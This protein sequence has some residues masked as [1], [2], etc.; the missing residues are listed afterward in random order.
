MKK[1]KDSVSR[2]INQFLNSRLNTGNLYYGNSHILNSGANPER[3]WKDLKQ[4]VELRPD[5]DV[6]DVGCAEGLLSFEVAKHVSSVHGLD[7][8]PER[9]KWARKEAEKRGVKNVTFKS[10]SI[11]STPINPG[12]YDVVLFL[13][14]FMK[15]SG[16][17]VVG[18]PVLKMLLRAARRQLIMRYNVMKYRVGRAGLPDVY[19]LMDE[20]G[21]DAVCFAHGKR[22]GN[23]IVANRRGT[24]ARLTTAPPFLIVP[25]AAVPNHPCLKGVRIGTLKDYV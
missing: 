11:L 4:I 20:C 15:G 24:D 6:L 10:G 18:L 14:V 1:F 2:A 9:I 23:L 19:A 12:S 3:R 7:V 8:E 25:A 21:F 16:D 22:Q 5:D 13:S 17:N